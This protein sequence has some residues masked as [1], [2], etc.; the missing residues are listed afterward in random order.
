MATRLVELEADVRYQE[1]AG[2]GEPEFAYVA[3]QAPV[4]FSA[5]HGAV[6][7]RQGKPKDE[8]EYTAGLCQ[9]AAELGGAH[10]LYAR[11]RS[12]TDPNWYRDVPYKAC[13]RQVVDDHG[14][15]FVFDLHAAAPR[16]HFGIAL[17]TMR[18]QS[19]PERREGIIRVLA[20]YG[21]TPQGEGFDRLDVDNRFTARGRSGQETITRFAW[22]GLGVPAAQLELHPCVRIVE[23]RKD[24]SAK[25]AYCG[26]PALI[27]RT[28]RALIDLADYVA[29]VPS[30]AD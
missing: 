27:E 22:E 11:R 2:Q 19:C 13:L 1:L 18:G 14:I 28:V 4:L 3:G 9:L 12:A 24:A 16:R 10:A 8:D 26:S 15:R 30:E 5:P 17:G 20:D 25:R 29:S 6:H 21:F 23:R 7:T